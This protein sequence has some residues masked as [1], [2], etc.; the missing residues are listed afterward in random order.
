MNKIAVV[1]PTYNRRK[2]LHNLLQQL[3]QIENSKFEYNVVVV[4]DGST[5]GTIEMLTKDFP[6]V[7]IIYGNGNWWYTK[8]MNEGFKYLKDKNPDYLL[9]LNDDVCIQ[10]DYLS[11]LLNAAIKKN[12]KAIITSI[13]FSD[14]APYVLFDA[15]VS[16]IIWWRFKF[17]KYYKRF[18]EVKI[19]DFSG[20]VPT[21][22][23]TGRGT[24]IPA[25]ILYTL[26]M[27]DEKYIQYGSDLDLGLKAI[28]QGYKCFISYDAKVYSI[29]ETTGKGASFIKTSFFDFIK[30]LFNKYTMT[31]LPDSFRLAWNY[32][33]RWLY[34]LTCAIIILGNFKA[35]FFNK[36]Y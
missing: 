17:V 36:K 6:E 11:F 35:Y 21:E 24:L 13:C 14:K 22:I 16:R 29:I 15:G 12:D 32:G 19:E 7:H 18:S 4:V 34:P 30:N 33:N 5:D 27:Y 3:F 10:R 8:S 28:K 20:L 25:H 1:I 2:L 23:V 31:Y 9:L 26:N